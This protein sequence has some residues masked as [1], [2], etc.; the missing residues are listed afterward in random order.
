MHLFLDT[1][2]FS[3]W[4]TSFGTQLQADR[5]TTLPA[6]KLLSQQS[7]NTPGYHRVI[8]RFLQIITGLRQVPACRACGSDSGGR[9]CQRPIC[10][11][12]VHRAKFGPQFGTTQCAY[13]RECTA[14][15]KQHHKHRG[16]KGERGIFKKFQRARF[17]AKATPCTWQ[18]A[19]IVRQKAKPQ[20]SS[21]PTDHVH[22]IVQTKQP[23][24][25]V[26]HSIPRN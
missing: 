2:T 20:W 26:Y 4:Y 3:Q 11:Q 18:V 7:L 17:C 9:Q 14:C 16:W 8:F 21:R 1:H 5:N 6:P 12:G 15:R 10:S 19:A 25:P 23:E 13:T 24:K 22:R